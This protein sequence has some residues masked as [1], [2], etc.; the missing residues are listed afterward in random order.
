MPLFLFFIGHKRG[1]RYI[2]LLG[3]GDS[4]TC[5][6]V[7]DSSPYGD[8]EVTKIHCVGHVQKRPGSHKKIKIEI[9]V[10]PLSDGKS[11]KGVGRLTDKLADELPSYYG[12]AMLLG[13]TLTT[14]KK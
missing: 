11:I 5:Q 8:T 2:E 4:K 6:C 3:D 7:K 1:A 12:K 9:R 13:T 14:L 10:T